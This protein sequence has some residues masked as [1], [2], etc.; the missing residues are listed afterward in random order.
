MQSNAEDLETIQTKTQ[1]SISQ[2]YDF[3][4]ACEV[5]QLIAHGQ[6]RESHDKQI[7]TEQKQLFARIGKRLGQAA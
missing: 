5:T 3:Y 1:F 7:D 2:V 4:N 6:V